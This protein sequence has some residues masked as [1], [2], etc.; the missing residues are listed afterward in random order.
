MIASFRM[1]NAGPKATAAWHALFTRVFADARV[2]VDI[3]EHRFPQP[4]ESLWA[5]PELCAAF[6]C[7]WPFARSGAAMQPIAAPIPSPARYASLPRYCSDYLAREE[8]GWTRVEDAFGSRFGWMAENSH[9]GFNAPRAHLASLRGGRDAL[10]REVRGPLGNPARAIEALRAGEIDA[11]AIDGFYLDLVRH[12][13]PEKL[14]G[15]RVVGHTPWSPIPLLVAAP[16]VARA[17]VGALQDVLLGVHE[18]ADYAPLLGDVLLQRFVAP[19][20][21]RYAALEELAHQAGRSG[22][23]VIR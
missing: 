5:E 10:F 12:H 4:I 20:A 15:L 19:E 18:R 6:M 13:D 11:T 23:A 2:A 21:H 16:G 3:V 7:G 22:Y 9:S 17:A 8:S 14:V 1:Y